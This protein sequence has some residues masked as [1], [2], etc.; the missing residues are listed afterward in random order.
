MGILIVMR[1][2]YDII[3]L[4]LSIV[5][6]LDIL[7]NVRPGLSRRA[8]GQNLEGRRPIIHFALFI[9]NIVFP[10]YIIIENNYINIFKVKKS[11]K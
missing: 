9:P 6:L 3:L 8:T 7:F 10:N 5:R 1:D 2:K 11:K 4:I